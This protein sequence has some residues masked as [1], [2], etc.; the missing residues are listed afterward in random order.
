MR[1]AA[2]PGYATSTDGIDPSGMAVADHHIGSAD[3]PL[4]VHHSA[5]RDNMFCV[6]RMAVA[7]FSLC[8]VEGDPPSRGGRIRGYPTG[9]APILVVSTVTVVSVLTS[10]VSTTRLLVPTLSRRYPSPLSRS[11]LLRDAHAVK[12]K[13]HREACRSHPADISL[14]QSLKC[15]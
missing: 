13:K 4:N 7:L 14:L 8:C 1:S 2:S 3:G 5:Y 15:V 11:L 12:R 9:P 10:V 6:S